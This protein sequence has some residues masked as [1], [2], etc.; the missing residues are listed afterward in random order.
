MNNQAMQIIKLA[1]KTSCFAGVS[2]DRAARWFCDL[3]S[4][5]WPEDFPIAKPAGYDE[6]SHPEKYA[7]PVAKLALEAIKAIVPL[8]EQFR[9]WHLTRCSRTNEE[10]EQWW[11]EQ[12]VNH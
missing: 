7:D 4:W 6:M 10:F 5:Q 9:A 3:N 12:S 11:S 8:K 1:D 2:V